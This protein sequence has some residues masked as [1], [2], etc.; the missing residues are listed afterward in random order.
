[1]D[2]MNN[3]NFDQNVNQAPV[4]S[5]PSD[6]NSQNNYGTPS[7][8]ASQNPV[9]SQ[10]APAAKSDIQIDE[11]VKGLV[12]KVTGGFKEKNYK[13]IA[14]TA[15]VAVLALLLVIGIFS[16]VVSFV[17]PQSEEVEN[18]LFNEG[19]VVVS[20]G[21]KYGYIN[22]KGQLKIALQF[23][24]ATS[25][26]ADGYAVVKTGDSYGM[27][28]KKGEYVI[29]PQFAYL[30]AFAD[31]KGY[32]MAMTSDGKEG[33]VDNKGQWKIQPL[34]DSVQ[35]FGSNDLAPASN[36]GKWGFI[37]RKGD[38]KINP[39]FDEVTGFATS[40]KL[41]AVQAG[42]MF[43]YINAK[44]KYVINPQ[45]K[46]AYP[47]VNGLAP[48]ENSEGKW[49]FVNE[50]GKL[51]INY[52]FDGAAYFDDKGKALVMQ[53]GKFG[54]INKKGAYKVNPQ[55][56][57]VSFPESSVSSPE[58]IVYIAYMLEEFSYG[59]KMIFASGDKYGLSDTKG[60]YIINPMYER[61]S[62]AGE[63]LYIAMNDDG[64]YG[65]VTEKGKEKIFFQ[66]DS[67]SAFSNGLARVRSGESYGFI[68]K[69]GKV[70]INFQ[71]ESATSF[72]DDGYTVV[73][74]NGKYGIANKKGNIVVN[75]D[76]DSIG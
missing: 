40:S 69:S 51:V 39:Q 6:F 25:F 7:Y 38:W 75:P 34:F 29:N 21:G 47:F 16:A 50:K 11:T 46:S 48:V 8:D 27:I 9:D 72:Y 2:N 45:F 59:D 18:N 22:T 71:F 53:G 73:K 74:Q 54:F 63:N 67:A 55:F 32:R 68:N 61:L 24:S 12:S 17:F 13:V 31:E 1:M 65:Y 14:A 35:S 15:A 19:L 42:D 57:N 3:Q 5:Q 60:N 44:G 64:K 70:V 4:D 26:D 10:T 41:C 56:S 28:N 36:D 49:G 43:G 37:N 33:F 52:Q 20:K 58:Y 23:D 62:Y 76:Y 66:F 30:S